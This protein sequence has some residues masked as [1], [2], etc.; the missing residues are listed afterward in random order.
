MLFILGMTTAKVWA[1]SCA[2]SP[3]GTP[4]CQSAWTHS[5]VFA[6][7]VQEITE[8][9]WPS[10]SIP[11][12]SPQTA[13]SPSTRQR[14]DAPPLPTRRKVRF[15]ITEVLTGLDPSQKEIAIATGL[16]GADCGYGFQ[17]G[18]EYI[19]YTYNQPE[20]LSTGICRRPG[21][22]NRQPRTSSTSAS[23]LWPRRS[24]KSVSPRSIHTHDGCGFRA[25]SNMWKACREYK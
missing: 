11:P 5:A 14:A 19:V 10:V 17:R 24:P 4:P 8:P 22:S 2:V 1:C 16:Y 6:G 15:K 13:T 9:G 25:A 12:A 23:L 20:G 7:S 18:V 3:T 21:P